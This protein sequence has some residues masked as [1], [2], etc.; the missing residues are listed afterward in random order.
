MKELDQLII[1]VL[2]SRNVFLSLTANVAY[3]LFHLDTSRLIILKIVK[4]LYLE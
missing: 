3:W 2:S 4:Q 1:K